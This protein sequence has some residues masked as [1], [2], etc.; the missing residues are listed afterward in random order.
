MEY[1]DIV[2]LLLLL[3]NTSSTT[4]C[5]MLCH[6]SLSQPTFSVLHFEL[7]SQVLPERY[8]RLLCFAG[9]CFH[10]GSCRSGSSEE[11]TNPP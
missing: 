7:V 8:L 3:K 6:L 10:G 9:G 1:Y 11:A 4:G 2:E 5:N